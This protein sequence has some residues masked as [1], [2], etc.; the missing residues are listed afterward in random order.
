MFSA[1]KGQALRKTE[2]LRGPHPANW[3]EDFGHENGMYECACCHCG[4]HFLGHKRRPACRVCAGPAPSDEAVYR[5][6]R[7]L[8]VGRPFR[9]FGDPLAL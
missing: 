6:A 9:P 7:E 4:R 3:P 2:A 8:L 1:L 5:V